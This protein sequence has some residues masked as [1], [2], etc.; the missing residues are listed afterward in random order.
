MEEPMHTRGGSDHLDSARL[1]DGQEP[2]RLRPPRESERARE[3]FVA[4]GADHLHGL[5]TL[6]RT[7][8]GLSVLPLLIFLECLAALSLALAGAPPARIH[9]L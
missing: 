5:E 1:P 4:R 9:R 8:I 7:A 3:L 6:L 2:E